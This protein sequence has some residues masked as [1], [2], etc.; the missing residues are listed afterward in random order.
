[1]FSYNVAELLRSAPGTSRVYPV[2]VADLAIADD[3]TLVAPIEGEVKLQRTGD[4]ILASARLNTVVAE[5]CSRCLA[6]TS[7][8]IEVTITEEALPSVDIDSGLAIEMGAERDAIR[9]DGHHELHLAPAVR[10]AISL[11]EPFAVLC[12]PD[13]RGLCLTCGVDLNLDPTHRHADD[14]IDPRLAGLAALRDQLAG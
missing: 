9:L 1:M 4:S 5:T 2:S 7:A 13:C 8:P 12:R 14:D 11:A 6:P 3:I 10:D